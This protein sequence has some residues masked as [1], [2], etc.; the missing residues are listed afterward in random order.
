MAAGATGAPDSGVLSDCFRLLR[1]CLTVPKLFPVL[2]W[3]SDHSAGDPKQS[4]SRLCMVTV[5]ITC[6]T[7]VY[8]DDRSNRPKD[9]RSRVNF[10]NKLHRSWNAPKSFVDLDS[11]GVV[12]LDTSVVSDVLGLKAFYD[13][14][15]PTLVL[16]GMA[17]NIIQILVPDDRAEPRGFCNV[18][19]LL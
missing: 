13:D 2:L 14:A 17:K 11:P 3:R 18:R 15:E 8:G 19:L 9:A 5:Y 4:S 7:M 6:G 16:P 10:R 1:N 12:A